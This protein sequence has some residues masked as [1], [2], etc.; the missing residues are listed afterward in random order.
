MAGRSEGP[1]RHEFEKVAENWYKD[2]AKNLLPPPQTEKI[3]PIKNEVY[4]IFWGSRTQLQHA[5]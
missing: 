2:F 3:T 4:Q 5:F 1:G